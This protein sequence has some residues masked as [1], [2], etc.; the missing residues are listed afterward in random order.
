MRPTLAGGLPLQPYF[1][2]QYDLDD[3]FVPLQ[4]DASTYLAVPAL[5]DQR[6]LDGFRRGQL[7]FQ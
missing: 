2:Y 7:L 4:L 5:N 3:P 1:P 6:A